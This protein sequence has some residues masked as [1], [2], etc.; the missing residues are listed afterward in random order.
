[1]YAHIFKRAGGYELHLT[2]S[3]DLSSTL[4]IEWHA[5]KTSAKSSAKK[6]GAKPWNF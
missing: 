1:M 2:Q 5:N 4:A 6:M 3:P